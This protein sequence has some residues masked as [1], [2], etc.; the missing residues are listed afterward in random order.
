MMARSRYQLVAAGLWMSIWLF[1]FS[2]G[3]N[4]D[5]LQILFTASAVLGLCALLPLSLPHPLILSTLGVLILGISLRSAGIHLNFIAALLAVVLMGLA[6]ALG[7]R[8]GLINAKDSKQQTPEARTAKGPTTYQCLLWAWLGAGLISAFIAL[9]QAL[10]LEGWFYPWFVL[11]PRH[12]GFA[13]L[14]QRNLYATF[15]TTALLSLLCLVHLQVKGGI[16]A[17]TSYAK[18]FQYASLVAAAL[19]GMAGA[20]SSSRTGLLQLALVAGAAL[21]WRNRCH[22]AM[23]SVIGVCFLAYIATAF[24][25]PYLHQASLAPPSGLGGIMPGGAIARINLGPDHCETRSILWR[26]AWQLIQDRP[27]EGWGWREFAWAHFN[28]EL[29]PRFCRLVD[30]AHNLPLQLAAEL[31]LPVAGLVSGLLLGML[32]T[33]WRHAKQSAL[34]AWALAVVLAILLHSMVEFPLWHTPFQIAFGLCMGLLLSPV[35]PSQG[36]VTFARGS[37]TKPH[38]IPRLKAPLLG[39]AFLA[40]A[41][42]TLEYVRV[43]QAYLPANKRQAW[44]QQLPWSDECLFCNQRDFAVVTTT[45]IIPANA[46]WL[47]REALRLLH[48]SPEPRLLIVAIETSQIL[49]KVEVEAQLRKKFQAAYPWPYERWLQTQQGGL[50]KSPS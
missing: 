20:L 15:N 39:L 1:P 4:H 6:A 38:W 16:Q 22:R 48:F 45:P 31:G 32:Y 27:W 25:M 8:W 49:G 7:A 26:N 37:L 44:L 50:S 19:L 42:A 34:H 21:V 18:R 30:H 41:V 10:Q 12:E 36:A 2:F 3:P 14:R 29:E 5:A 28:A 46:G 43:S 47:H 9:C 33:G 17:S 40:L 11:T 35:S 13:N 23:W 24:Y